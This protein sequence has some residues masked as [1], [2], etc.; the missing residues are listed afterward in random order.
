MTDTATTAQITYITDLQA[1]GIAA[2]DDTLTRTEWAQRPG[3]RASIEAETNRERRIADA[4]LEYGEAMAKRFAG[5]EATPLTPLATAV[6]DAQ[7]DYADAR[8]A[9]QDLA[10]A[11][12]AMETAEAALATAVEDRMWA[13]I[14]AYKRALTVDPAGLTKAE[15]STLI[16]TLE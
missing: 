13:G 8:A 2:G 6:L 10:A 1:K 14:E 4:I 16:D 9:G 3:N 5:A 7:D 11:E 12:A 15:A